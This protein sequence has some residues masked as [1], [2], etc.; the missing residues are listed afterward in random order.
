[1]LFIPGCYR[2]ITIQEANRSKEDHHPV[3]I[4]EGVDHAAE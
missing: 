2:A 1:M 3:V 4:T